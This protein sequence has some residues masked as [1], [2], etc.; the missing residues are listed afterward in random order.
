MAHYLTTNWTEKIK[1][2]P[3]AN[4]V[5]NSKNYKIWNV[6]LRSLTHAPP[7]GHKMTE[8][9]IQKHS[10]DQVFTF[11][12]E[13][14]KQHFVERFET[15]PEVIQMFNDRNR[16]GGYVKS[17]RV[18]RRQQRQR[19]REQI[20]IM[21]M[22]AAGDDVDVVANE[23]DDVGIVGVPQRNRGKDEIDA[24]ANDDDEDEGPD[25]G[26][27]LF[28]DE[29][30]LES[31]DEDDL[32]IVYEDDPVTGDMWANMYVKDFINIHHPKQR[33]H[34]I[35]RIKTSPLSVKPPSVFFS[36]I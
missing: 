12:S 35:D 5:L 27:L 22:L 15:Q 30:D 8:E 16:V 20:D 9:F 23:G 36:D 31:L 33:V 29:D 26:G 14:R 17:K 1:N 25:V 3:V 10:T 24:D 7:F 4:M 6:T 34:I 11:E 32:Q 2:N 28:Y 13:N 18:K 21:G 19:Q